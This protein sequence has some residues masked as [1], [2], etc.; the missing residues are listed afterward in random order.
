M[1]QQLRPQEIALHPLADK[2]LSQILELEEP[3]FLD[4]GEAHF[5]LSHVEDYVRQ[6][7]GRGVVVEQHYI[8]R[9]FME[10]YSVFYSKSLTSY[11]NSCR[12][13]SFFSLDPAGLRSEFK[14]LLKIRDQKAFETASREFQKS[15]TSVSASLSRCRGALL[16]A[17][18]FGV[19]PANRDEDTRMSSRVLATTQPIF[20]GFL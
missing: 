9:D 6:H 18:S 10:E 12:R 3:P 2:T 5:Q 19:C 20:L 13:V 8:D 15:I 14:R 1:P 7:G 17:P 16:A 11:L 4:P